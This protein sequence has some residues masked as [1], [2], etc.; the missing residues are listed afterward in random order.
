MADHTQLPASSLCTADWVTVKEEDFENHVIP[1]EWKI[2]NRPRDPPTY[3][4]WAKQARNG[5]WAFCCVYGEEHYAERLKAL[6]RA[7][8]W[9]LQ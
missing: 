6:E 5:I 4:S 9:N 7:I 2:E 8:P 1:S 3:L